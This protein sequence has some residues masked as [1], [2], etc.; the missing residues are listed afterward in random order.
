MTIPTEDTTQSLSPGATALLAYIRANDYVTYAEM[1]RVLSSFMPVKGDLSAEVGHVPNLVLWVG[2]SQEWIQ[3]LN[4]LFTAGLIWRQPC[5]VLS[6]MVD[7]KVLTL[8]VAKRL[9]KGGYKTPHWGPTCY[10]PIEK[11]SPAEKQKYAK[12]KKEQM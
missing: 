4:E 3:T 6:Y 11:I 7:G 12:T 10:R 1:P 2:M 5:P 8:P 9:P